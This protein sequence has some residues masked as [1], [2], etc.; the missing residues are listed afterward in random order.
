FFDR[1]TAKGDTVTYI[2]TLSPDLHRIGEIK[3]PYGGSNELTFQYSQGGFLF[4]D[5]P[6]IFSDN[7]TSLLI[8]EPRNDT[9]FRYVDQATLEPLFRVEMGDYFPADKLLDEN[10]WIDGSVVD[11]VMK[12][13]RSSPFEKYNHGWVTAIYEGERYLVVE[14]G[15]NKRGYC[16]FDKNDLI[17]GFWAKGLLSLDGIA[18]TP[19]YIR[20]NQLVGYMQAIDIVDNAEQITDP[21]LKALAATLTENDNPVVVVA[22]L[23]E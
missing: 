22:K 19:C 15:S 6:P 1:S 7:G 2:E 9:V 18:F 12:N 16:I 8:K 4:Q 11:D 5:V 14:I 23:K 10:Q 21:D 20:D 17:H 3:I 13:R